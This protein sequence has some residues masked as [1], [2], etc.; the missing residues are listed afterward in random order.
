MATLTGSLNAKK[1]ATSLAAPI[2]MFLTEQMVLTLFARQSFDGW[3]GKLL[4]AGTLQ[5]LMVG[6]P[7][8]LRLGLLAFPGMFGLFITS[9]VIKSKPPQI[10]FRGVQF[11]RVKSQDF[12][13]FSLNIHTIISLQTII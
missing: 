8:A 2:S 1:G 13:K 5:G 9:I 7:A 11:I 10:H 12:D 4:Y 3:P 6:G